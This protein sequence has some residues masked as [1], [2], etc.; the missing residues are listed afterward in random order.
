[1]F[2]GSLRTPSTT[3]PCDDNDLDGPESGEDEDGDPPSRPL[4]ASGVQPRAL[5]ERHPAKTPWRKTST[6]TVRVASARSTTSR[7][8]PVAPTTLALTAVIRTGRASAR[9]DERSLGWPERMRQVSQS[10]G[11]DDRELTGEPDTQVI[12][13]ARD[14]PSTH[15][16]TDQSGKNIDI[17]DSV[18]VGTRK[19]TTCR[20]NRRPVGAADRSDR[21][22]HLKNGER[23]ARRFTAG[24]PGVIP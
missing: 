8:S 24:G 22:S 15:W 4:A 6:L 21:C 23:E 7:R 1:M 18:R 2:R 11:S 9:D 13:A 12:A 17:H 5:V 20:P 3:S 19:S 14:R 16:K 10:G